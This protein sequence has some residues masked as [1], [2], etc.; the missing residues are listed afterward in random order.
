MWADAMRH[1]AVGWEIVV[2]LGLGYLLGWALDRWL[3][4]SPWLKIVGLL[5]GGG[6]AV[7]ALVRVARQYREEVGPDDPLPPG[8]ENQPA[9]R[10]PRRHRRRPP[11]GGREQ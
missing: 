8:A 9:P 2:A 6:A 11:D 10:G 7:M 5:L 4:T 3:H 1:L